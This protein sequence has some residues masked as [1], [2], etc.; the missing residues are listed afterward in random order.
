MFARR[1]LKWVAFPIMTLVWLPVVVDGIVSHFEQTDAVA[2]F[3]VFWL[4]LVAVP[5]TI[6]CAVPLVI[7]WVRS[8]KRKIDSIESKHS[9]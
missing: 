4:E 5:A 7:M 2:D 8:V 3:G 9:G 6:V 1:F